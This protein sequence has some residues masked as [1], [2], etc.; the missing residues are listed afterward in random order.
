MKTITK[1]LPTGITTTQKKVGEK[2]IITVNKNITKKV[3]THFHKLVV[4]FMVSLVF[5]GSIGLMYDIFIQLST[6]A[7]IF[8]SPIFL[9]NLYLLMICLNRTYNIL[10]K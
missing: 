10:K 6:T 7:K 2:I 3:V 5:L 4:S 9:G 8:F 1:T